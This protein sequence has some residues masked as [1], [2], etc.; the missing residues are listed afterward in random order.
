MPDKQKSSIFE[1]AYGRLILP[2]VVIQSTLIAGGYATGRE[3]V[4]Y[5]A[6]FGAIGWVT[7]LTILI[8]FGV[9]A[10]LMFEVA[11]VFKAFDYKSLVK[12]FLGPLWFIYDIIYFL[13]AI[14][15]L[16][17]V[18]AATGSILKRTLGLDIWMG[19]LIIT[20]ITAILNFYGHHLIERF[21]TFGTIFLLFFFSILIFFGD[22][23]F[24]LFKLLD[25]L[26]FFSVYIFFVFLVFSKRGGD[27]KEVF[28]SGDT[29][30]AGHFPWCGFFLTTC[31]SI[32]GTPFRVS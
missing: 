18:I 31:R 10:F 30:M 20:V 28:A 15:I 13:L 12:Q 11:R 2:G 17:I 6:K 22:L 8:G 5:G 16:S 19:V 21:K 27:P 7:G 29:S 24:Y 14:L 25:I 32:P 9:M 4:E 26:F 23:W 1:G 3:V